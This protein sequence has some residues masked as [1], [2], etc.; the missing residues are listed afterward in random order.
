MTGSISVVKYSRSALSIL[1]AI[2]SGIPLRYR[3]RALDALFWS[4]AA[5]L[6]QT[7]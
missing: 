2:F 4:D 1:A 6:V 7:L 3:D 5:L